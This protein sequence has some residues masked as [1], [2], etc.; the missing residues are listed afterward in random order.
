MHAIAP[1]GADGQPV[2]L[3]RAYDNP[4]IRLLLI[5]PALMALGGLVSLSDRRLRFGLAARARAPVPVAAE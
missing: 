2:W 4:W 3:V 5:G 1:R